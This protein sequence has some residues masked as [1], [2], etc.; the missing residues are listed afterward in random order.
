[1]KNLLFLLLILVSCVSC[2]KDINTYEGDSGIYFADEGIFSD[3][4]RV[5]WGVKKFR[6]KDAINSIESLS[7]WK[8]CKL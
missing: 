3:T 8:Y 1:M 6:Y 7:V 5:A 2:E 4:L